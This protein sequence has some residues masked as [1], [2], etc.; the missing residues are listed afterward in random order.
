MNDLLVVEDEPTVRALVGALLVVEGIPYRTVVH[1]GE[2]LARVGEARPVV[3]LNRYPC[4][5]RERSRLL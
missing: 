3:V 5:S 2:A 4:A 1:G